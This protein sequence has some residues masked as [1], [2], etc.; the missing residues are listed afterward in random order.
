MIE[1]ITLSFALIL[2]ATA[3]TWPAKELRDR[4]PILKCKSVWAALLVVPMFLLS[5][6]YL[7]FSFIWA[8]SGV[9][10]TKVCGGIILIISV[11]ELFG[12]A[13]G[14]PRNT[15]LKRLDGAVCFVCLALIAYTK[16]KGW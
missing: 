5:I 15:F 2:E 12:V 16:T 13:S 6:S 7:L 10:P 8:L 14:R 3:I 4:L 11:L 1:W 9:P